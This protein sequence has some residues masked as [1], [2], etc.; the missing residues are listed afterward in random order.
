MERQVINEKNKNT[1]RSES[2][3]NNLKRR[4]AAQSKHKNPPI[5]PK[6]PLKNITNTTS[7]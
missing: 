4:K 5:N 3:R 7:D 6:K 1:R 2:L